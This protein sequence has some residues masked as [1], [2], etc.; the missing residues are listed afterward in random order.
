MYLFLNR[1]LGMSVGKSAAQ[2]SHAAVE[3]YVISDPDMREQ[4]HLGGHYAKI[5][6]AVDDAEQLSTVQQYIEDR[7]FKTRLI[8]D[9]GRTEIPPFSKTALGVEI[10]D[11]ADEHVLATFGEFKLY[12]KP[13]ASSPTDEY[14]KA[15]HIVNSNG[16]LKRR[17]QQHMAALERIC[18][19]NTKR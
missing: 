5:V 18:V 13:K 6:L 8:I 3:A 11:K 19:Q 9:E 14:I 4:W 10:V 15:Y 16:H 17:G 12:P 2:A 7:T 1:G